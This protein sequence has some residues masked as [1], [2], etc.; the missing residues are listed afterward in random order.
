MEEN[1]GIGAWKERLED[2]KHHYEILVEDVT[3]IDADRVPL[4]NYT[5]PRRVRPTMAAAVRQVGIWGIH[6][7]N[8][9]GGRRGLI[10]NAVRV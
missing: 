3:A 10:K 6:M 5:P 7:A 2:I 1:C 4:P 8:P 9:L